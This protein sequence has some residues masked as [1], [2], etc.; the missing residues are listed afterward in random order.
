MCLE[1]MYILLMYKFWTVFLVL[2]ID[3]QNFL[4]AIRIMIFVLLLL[5]YMYGIALL[6]HQKFLMAFI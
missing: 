3:L 6:L 4:N 5:K 1:E 2:H